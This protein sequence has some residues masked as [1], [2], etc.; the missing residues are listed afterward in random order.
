MA[1]AIYLYGVM[2]LLLDLKIP[3]HARERMLM[4]YLRYKGQAELS[5]IDDVCKLCG[6]TGFDPNDPQR[7]PANYPVEFFAR[8]PLPASLVEMV[9]G[10]LRSDDVY[11]QMVCFPHP[12]HRTTA[13][14]AQGGMLYVILYFVPHVLT[15][16]M[17]SM[18]EVVDKHF[19]DCWIVP[20]FLGYTVDLSVEWSGFRAASTA[21]GNTVTPSTLRD[22]K[23]RFFEAVPRLLDELRAVLTE[24][25]LSDEYVLDSGN[26]LMVLLRECNV[27][28]RWL[29]LHCS[30][31]T[32]TN[33][34]NA[35]LMV[36]GFDADLVLQLLLNT[37]QLEFELKQLYQ[38]LLDK[39]QQRWDALRSEGSERMSEMSRYFTGEL[40]LTRVKKNESLERWFKDIS[41]R[42]AELD[43]TD[44]TSAG[45]KIQ[46]LIQALEEV[47][48][49]HQIE[50]SLQ[51]K[52][53]LAE[54]RQ[55]MSQMLR[56]VNIR[57][58]YLV[59]L[60]SVSDMSYAW[61]HL[62]NDYIPSMQARIKQ[63]PHCIIKLR[64]IFLKQGSILSTTLVRINQAASPDLL[65]V[66]QY[67]SSELV[68][69]VR[70]VLAIIPQSMFQILQQIVLLQTESLHE[71]PT[72]V[73]RDRL[74]EVA[75]L[76]E[77]YH[78]AKLTHL[79][80]VYTEGILAMEKT[81]VGVIEVDPRALLEEGIRRE[82][83]QRIAT[84]MNAA[85][86]FGGAA[87]AGK[88]GKGGSA[89]AVSSSSAVV[90]FEQ[91]LGNLATV[92]DGFRRSFQYI[93]DYVGISGLKIWQEEFSR[94]VYYNV[95]QECNSFLKNKVYDH[96]SVY[97]SV[98]VPIPRFKSVD[99]SV[100]FIGRL[101]RALQQHTS[102]TS[103]LFLD[104]MSAWYD[105][106]G[107]ELVGIRTFDQLIASVGAFGVSGLTRLFSFMVV[108][109]LHA[110]FSQVR[111]QLS[112]RVGRGDKTETKAA[113]LKEFLTRFWT[114]LSPTSTI[115][116]N[117]AALYGGGVRTLEPL[118]PS[119]MQTVT[120][121][122]H[123]QL[124][125]RQIANSLKFYA[126]LDSNLLYNTLKVADEAVL[127]D[128]RLHYRDPEHKPYPTDENALLP[129]LTSYLENS[130]LHDP[131]FKI[132]VTSAPIDMLPLVLFL[133]VVSQCPRLKYDTNLKTLYVP[134]S[135]KKGDRAVVDGSPFA[136]GVYTLLKQFHV[137][138]MQVF[139]SLVGQYVRAFVNS[140]IGD[141]K[142]AVLSL[143]PEALNLLHFLE[144]FCK[145]ARIPRKDVEPY[146]PAFLWDHFLEVL[147]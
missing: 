115:P 103:T 117:A 46:Q 130:G 122:G 4:A 22:L 48:Q 13:L 86:V 30:A 42:I 135:G 41:A 36:A 40:P 119:F 101:A 8:V 23:H 140:A 134:P 94:I 132:Y 72:K 62:V 107:R 14:S 102:A 142:K 114:E 84:T 118:W 110:F 56:V 90:D 6:S 111:A 55:F 12:S 37:A 44:S 106:D 89:L 1:E 93:Q 79:V 146:L 97:Q 116:K 15:R 82:L 81:M 28:V 75:M 52:S 136:V 126:Y 54:T 51:V 53:F 50:S 141:G 113:P 35:E 127:R 16:E 34:K 18:R 31:S 24:G 80:S 32:H 19:S 66:S 38:G 129:E 98:T 63:D 5:Y 21:V 144:M 128:V 45:R 3:G 33:K 73:E 137:Q 120:T 67:Y 10:R 78:L 91:R 143:P 57:E 64:S 17:A 85:L 108:K 95:E 58:S 99:E 60:S 121:V 100:N 83:V 87:A 29:M 125:L 112:P 11:N 26:K 124:L 145:Y 61:P 70:R 77:R 69:Y 105:L 147:Q 49:F 76:D 65:S 139:L 123:I 59:S 138:H 92:M 133:F 74:R 20:W 88:G 68:M 39:K 7:K 47:E 109:E 43:Y 71:L 27:T 25:V 131:L 2:L 96:Q 9:V 104:A